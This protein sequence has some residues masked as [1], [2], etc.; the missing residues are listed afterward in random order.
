VDA[1]DSSPLLTGLFGYPV[2]HSIS[3]AIH[4][5]AFRARRRPGLYLAF[6]VPP[7]R[8]QAALLGCRALSFRGL[9]LTIPHKVAAIPLLSS[10]SREAR[11]LGAVNTVIFRAGRLFGDNT[12]GRG[13]VRA[14][15]EEGFRLKGKKIFLAGAGGAGRA[16]AMRSALEGASSIAIADPLASRAAGLAGRVNRTAPGIA[17]AAPIGSTDW[18]EALAEADLAVNASPLGMKPSDPLPFP[19]ARLPRSSFIFDLVYNPAET[20]LLRAARR[21]GRRGRNGLGMLVHQ[22]ALSWEL[23]TGEEAPLEAMKDAARSA[24]AL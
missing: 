23:W 7:R 15:E 5:A 21:I 17:R 14:V 16:V 20:R 12:D 9:N 19:P 11:L 13:F 1:P 3:P 22:A 24:M 6:A 4:A 10:L 8:L 2:R 18:E